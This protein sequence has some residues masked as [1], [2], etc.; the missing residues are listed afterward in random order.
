MQHPENESSEWN[1]YWPHCMSRLDALTRSFGDNEVKSKFTT[2]L[3]DFKPDVVHLNNIHTQLSP[4]IAEIA[5]EH[6]I[7]V[8]W[9]LHDTKLVC[10]CYTCM[11][12]SKW[13]TECF[14]DKKAVIRHICMHGSF[15]Q[16]I[17]GYWEAKKWNKDILQ[18]YTDLFIAPSQFMMDTMVNAGMGR[19]SVVKM[20]FVAMSAKHICLAYNI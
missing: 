16:S 20:L 6:G 3:N 4:V 19:I 9:T 17:I 8:V 18:K 14:T 1:K 10:P 5:H 12:D 7:R 15:M 2:L 13:C 11:R